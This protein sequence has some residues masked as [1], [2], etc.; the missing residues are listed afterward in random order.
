MHRNIIQFSHSGWKHILLSLG[1]IACAA[2]AEAQVT[3]AKTIGVDYTTLAA[4]ITDLN[5]NG[6]SGA[7]TINVPAT[8]TE[9]APSGGYLLGSNTLNASVSATNTLTIK[10]SGAGVNPVL[11]AP[12][13]TSTTV[14]GIFIIRGT[15]YTT[16]DGI[17]VTEA[18]TNT[19]PTTQMEWGYALVKLNA[20]APF[21][22]SHNVIIKN[23]NITLNQA[24]TLSTGIYSGNHVASSTTALVITATSDALNNCQFTNNA[25][26]NVNTG[27]ALNGYVA[28]AAPYDL[29][30]QSN[31][32]GASGAGN[33][34]T[35][36]GGT[37]TAA[38]GISLTGQNN[39]NASYNSITSAATPGAGALKAIFHGIGTNSSFTAS[40]NNIQL[41]A[42][43]GAIY[44]IAN[45]T[46]V[47][48]SGISGTGTITINNNNFH[49]YSFSAANSATHYFAMYNFAGPTTGWPLG[50]LLM[51]NNTVQNMTNLNATGSIYLF[52]NYYCNANDVR[53]NNNKINSL[54]RTTTSGSTYCYYNYFGNPTGGADSVVG[55][56]I[57]NV[58]SPY[59]LYG[60]YD[61]MTVTTR[62]RIIMNDTLTNDTASK[63][64]TFYYLYSIYSYYGNNITI[65]NNL[66]TNLYA[67][68]A[69]S[70]YVYGIYRYYG[71][72]AVVSNNTITNNNS[73]GL[74]GVYSSS[75]AVSSVVNNNIVRN[76][77][78]TTGT[79]YG[80]YSNST[81]TNDIY[82][83][84]ITNLTSTTGSFYC[85]YNGGGT[86]VNV[87]NDT[88]YNITTNGG[89][90]YGYYNG[91][92]TTVNAHDNLLAQL[93]DNGTS[94]S[95]YGLYAIGGTTFNFYKNLI[96]TVVTQAT[97]GNAYGIYESGPTTFNCYKNKLSYISA[98]G[99]GS[100]VNGM[101]LNSGT[102]TAYNNLV[103]DLSTPAYS[104][105]TAGGGTQLVGIYCGS[106]TNYFIYYNTVYLTGGSAGI[107]FGSTAVYASTTPNVTM[108]NNVFV[109]TCTPGGTGIVAAYRRNS[110]S[111]TTYVST[112]NNNLF[113]AGTP[114]ANT[115]ILYDGTAVY[116][117]LADYKAHVTPADGA[118]VTENVTFQA[119]GGVANTFLHPSLTVPTQIESN[120]VPIA[121]ITDD[122]Y[123][124]I[125]AGSTGYAGSGVAPD[126]GAVEDNY[127]GL[128][129]SAPNVELTPLSYTCS[130]G[131][132][133]FSTVITDLSGVP[134]TGT[135]V[136]RVYYKKGAGI[137]FSKPGTLTAG[138]ANNGTWS[139]TIAAADMGGL[140]FG[141]VV[142]YFIIA[143]DVATPI[144]IGSVPAGAVA[145]DVNTITTFPPTPDTFSINASLAGTY[146]V[147]AAGTYTT[148]TSAVAAY[149][150]GCLTGPVT[151]SL[152]DATYG[153]ETLPI[154][155]GSNPYA[156]ATNTLTIKPAA[157]VTPTISGSSSTG[158]FVLNGA[159]YVIIDGSNSPVTNSVCPLV[160]STRNLT[161][162]NTSTSTT[163]AV[164]WLQT[165]TGA[166]SA[167]NNIVRNCN[168]TGSG[169]T[170]TLFGIGSGGTTVAYTSL[171]NGN[172]NNRFENN[173]VQGV[174][175]GIFSMGASATNKNS[176]TVINQNVMTGTAPN[177]IRN[178]GIFTGFE[179]NLT[180]SGNSLANITNGISN[181]I[182]GIN[183][184]FSNNSTSTT[185]TTGNEVTNATVT[186]N[187]LD[188]ITQT[189]TY[190]CLGIAVSGAASGTNL[191][192]NN[193]L[194]GVVSN[195]TS[196]DFSSSIFIGGAAG[197]T[198]NV[199]YNAVNVTGTI[200]GASYPNYA[201]SIS[202]SN[203]VVNIKNNIFVNNN[204]VASAAYETAI[205]L[206]YT[207]YSNLSS[208]YNDFFTVGTNL[209]RVGS[210]SAGTALT[211][212]A[213]WQ[214]TTG[215]DLHS[216][217]VNPGFV[218][219]SD[220]H[221]VP[222]SANEQLM[223]SG[224]VVSVTTDYDCNPR[225]ATTPDIGLNEFT[226]PPCGPVTAGAIV[227][228]SP[229]FCG[230]GST[231]LTLP[232]ASTGIGVVY[233]WYTSTDSVGWT[234]IAGATALVYTTPT[235]TATT[236]YRVKMRCTYSGTSDSSSTSVIIHPL[237]VISVSPDGGAICSTGTGLAM[238]AS[239]ASTYSW[240]PSTGLS[241]TTGATVT[242]NPIFDQVYTVTGTDVFGC[243]G[244]HS[245]S[246]TVSTPPPAIAVSPTTI[247]MCSND[248]AHVLVASGPTTPSSG[249]VADSTGTISVTVPDATA[250]GASI[251]VTVTG[252]PGG[253]TITG[254]TAKFNTTMTFD[255][256]L[257]INLT[258]PNGNT[259]NLVNR[260]GGGGANF[261][262]T[263]VSSAGGLALSTGVAPF[264]GTYAADLATA[265]G[266]T[267][268][269][270][271]NT[272][273]A[274]LYSLPNGT[275]TLSARDWAGGDV[276]TMTSWTITINY[277]Y[278]PIVTW[279]PLSGLY[280][281]S[282]ATVPYAGT[283]N[284]YVYA[285]PTA[286]TTYTVS[287]TT[288]GCASTATSIV[289]V[290]PAPTPFAITGG[291]GYCPG[292]AGAH[293]GLAGSEAGVS[294]QLY[295]GATAVGSP[296]A[297]TGSALDF[298][299]QPTGS[300]SATAVNATTG[301][302]DSM[303]GSVA[304][305][306]HPL[307]A[308]FNV[309]GGGAY[310]AGGAGV[311]V[312]LTGSES[313]VG[314]Q[315]YNGTTPVGAAVAGTGGVI[316]FGSQTAAGVYTV[317]AT[318]TS[319]TCSI[320]MTGSA[321]IIVNPLPTPHA[322][323]GG[324]AYCVGGTGTAV[325]LNSSDL[326]INYQLYRGATAV[327]SPVAGTGIAISFGLQTAAGTY[328]VLATNA[329]TGC[330][331]G[332][333]GTVTITIV[334][335][336][337][338][339][340]VTGGGHYCAGGTGVTVGLSSSQAG[341]SYQ[342]YNGAAV[343]GAP[344]T[345]TGTAISFG[346]YTDAGTYTV[347]ATNGT[348]CTS[349]M[350]GSATIV[351]DPLPTVFNLTG[352]GVYCEGGSG[353]A[354]G[355]DG[356]QSGFSY[357]LYNGGTIG[358][359][360]TGTGGPIS[361]GLQ[362]IAGSYMVIATNLA[363]GCGAA[364]TGSASIFINPIVPP[365]VSIISSLGDTVCA[366]SF[367]TFTAVPVN[368]GF[369]PTYQW[370]V[371][372]TATGTGTSFSYIPVNGDLVS[373][374]I[375]SS[376]CA[377]PD[378]ASSAV[379]MTVTTYV[380]PTVHIIAS[381]GD[382]ACVGSLVTFLAT[383][384]FG[385]TAP[386]YR[387]V[388][389]GINVA[390]G[391]TYTTTVADGDN[392][393]CVLFSS[394]PCSYYDSV[395]SNHI[396]MH[397]SP[398]ATPSLYVVAHPGLSIAPGQSDTL[399]AIVS[400]A[401]SAPIYQWRLNGVVIPGATSAIYIS[402]TFVNGDS[403]S[404]Y[405]TSTGTCGGV[406]VHRTVHILVATGST[407]I[408]QQSGE[409]N[410][411]LLPNP[412]KG[413]FRLQGDLGVTTNEQVDIEVTNMLG[414]VIYSGNAIAK[415]GRLD[416]QVEL[417][418]TLANGTYILKM[419]AGD[420]QTIMHFIVAQ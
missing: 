240:T 367:V 327:G 55:N 5:S 249:S 270:I 73:Y 168:I 62:D 360:V 361:F 70:G 172:N 211:T 17:D 244:T 340:S 135:L 263:T 185:I 96:D 212:L 315:L 110:T 82:N 209:A 271:T 337:T 325:G 178:N 359:P 31:I 310:C 316:T 376:S 243:T 226:V 412:N 22:G 326:G 69:N 219:P 371:N 44:G 131:D 202:G 86:T 193:M 116:Q 180:I 47:A 391:P 386:T 362:T 224:V 246:I 254:V 176:G 133:T 128:D 120:G 194:S 139:F 4:A 111:L 16:I 7:V 151:F 29:Y 261:T 129:L 26:T 136:P 218:S 190:S 198:T 152:T 72:N 403:V 258:A 304:T 160:A 329:T 118:S 373:V 278:N 406:T 59:Y 154:T 393:Y 253:A 85:L 410:V 385:G 375:T 411:R 242:A 341:V 232:A 381:T 68:P 306:V 389:N 287:L 107:N 328:S 344:V 158:V 400:G 108:N 377:S 19:T 314:Y 127:I 260:R 397:A 282:T 49:N 32:V 149:N 177:N 231:T 333:I 195:G 103:G 294:Y 61:Y 150:A 201:I 363:T 305:F 122:H 10:K 235:V 272:A 221:L 171:G 166:N 143:Q 348:G 321:T 66:L 331:R 42:S 207:T 67:V 268:L 215:N 40:N 275:W 105:S 299:L 165:A 407:G 101:Y 415:G 12:V 184:G 335:L 399:V 71:N 200:T 233:Q 256:D 274:A 182:I 353:V 204:T 336:P 98:T 312:G 300:Y 250:S 289:N 181:D 132:R 241:G 141:N 142:S 186:N 104:S 283:N 159:D 183:L 161:I 78:I 394:Y 345:G 288:G 8:Y 247:T 404:C 245:V 220:L 20:S 236:Y 15:D 162:S 121:S 309:T 34:I 342:L 259:I 239:G 124:T 214:T 84:S 366:G 117:T 91:S 112:S 93:N 76:N 156:S 346:S 358:S 102:V 126:L 23:C 252:I 2:A 416:E 419:R 396:I 349:N 52:Y 276:A 65:K 148:V 43:T 170:Q 338:V 230:S 297:G 320:N 153:T 189:N 199:F 322:I 303:T 343:A 417:S 58:S 382:T 163:S 38:N 92:G 56:K 378:T 95:V 365:T 174:Q 13:G 227:A 51:N 262:N 196:G 3:G 197:G 123:G 281:D 210:L 222:T 134:T 119:T 125:R 308:V 89:S 144:N 36:F 284:T 296:V 164:V 298:G 369:S 319:T 54:F 113:Y 356:S 27:I 398:A 323:T 255:G 405:V 402:S 392:V 145:T 90:I 280:L 383:P 41:R 279:A 401:G 248:S 30:D 223:D 354:I 79:G 53:F 45:G 11:T 228:G 217:N 205:G 140:T 88:V 295:N 147:G 77:T 99:S 81:G 269:P 339:Y 257:T 350:T 39:A 291:G 267:G 266:T 237:P 234:A 387:W 265:V 352:G 48:N 216:K 167:T 292:T 213:A 1:F 37:A 97:S 290:N 206:A 420:K 179:D 324:G 57:T 225:S 330:T 273:W 264:T 74:Y 9:I 357:Q 28:A 21:D 130:T 157:G 208:D 317:S 109:N 238:T 114:S 390:T 106:G 384:T 83:N 80:V 6:I 191:I 285:K 138:T 372:G 169:S 75:A 379:A 25:I 307:P 374:L 347:L 351:I 318:S 332:M 46:G 137:W 50:A 388:K 18:A 414:Q 395:F 187:K 94:G 408:A 14:D 409:W 192:A 87:Y 313:G 251:P 293:V 286:T 64:S 418:N 173:S 100:S 311:P 370:T 115:V 364:M 175:T 380:T 155:I 33:T 229:A 60:L 301:C 188:N 146:T 35:N 24:N 334:A 302:S 203:P 63:G 413:A 277:S 368:G 355:L